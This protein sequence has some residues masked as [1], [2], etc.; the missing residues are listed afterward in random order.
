L[1]IGEAGFRGK[2]RVIRE[3]KGQDLIVISA[4]VAASMAGP[5]STVATTDFVMAAPWAV[6]SAGLT[7][8]AEGTADS[9]QAAP[10]TAPPESTPP[11]PT[12][13]PAAAP[14]P[15]AAPPPPA[16]PKTTG[17]NGNE[18]VVSGERNLQKIDPLMGANKAAFQVMEKVDGMFV[19]PIAT[20][21]RKVLP[22]PV[23]NG[24]HNF[25]YNLTEPVNAVNYL[26]QLHP[27]KAV[28]TV[29]RFGINSTIGVAGLM[30][31]AKKKPFN[32]HYRPN[33]FANTL[34]YWGVGPGPYMFLPLVGPTT[35]RDLIG[36]L[37]DQSFLP[38]AVGKPFTSPYYVFSSGIIIALDY[39]VIIDDDLQKVR[40]TSS[41]YS[42]YRQIYLKTRYEEI[43]AL[44]GR[45]PLAKGEVGEAPFAKPLY[46]DDAKQPPAPAAIPSAALAPSPVA[47]TPVA[48]EPPA[49]V[50]ISVPIIEPHP[51]VEPLPEG[52]RVGAG[53]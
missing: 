50:F 48:A 26:L 10:V 5:A 47:A 36:T 46:P 52:Y 37:L 7:P 51:V 30:D 28:Q 13:T 9:G 23:R 18:I 11:A 33:G 43:E 31:V 24:L 19:A 12:D 21:Y 16:K 14:A 20:G 34:G 17:G 32:I 25:F 42:S 39:R 40:K 2:V 35:V 8:V 4:V 45:G 53:N 38:S 22:K 27:G 49:P 6:E 44:H 1:P 29:A 3:P 15:A 41:P